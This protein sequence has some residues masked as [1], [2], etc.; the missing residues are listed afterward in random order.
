LEDSCQ[1]SGVGAIVTCQ[2]CEDLPARAETGG[3]GGGL[4]CATLRQDQ[5]E[6][7]QQADDRQHR[8]GGDGED[9][10]DLAALR[11]ARYKDFRVLRKAA[12][13]LVEFALAISVFMLLVF[14]T[15]DLAR[16]YLGYMVVTNA[17]REASR[18]AA[19]HAGDSACAANAQQA[20]LNLAVGID[21]AALT[22]T[23]ACGAPNAALTYISVSGIYR[24]HSVV[25]LVGAM[26]GDPIQIQV[27]TS[28]I[29]G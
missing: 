2:F 5:P 24:F 4:K 23:V 17:A 28:A 27:N 1:Y 9:H 14:G 18:Y 16:A 22:L 6:R 25:P 3:I 26:L 21:A 13:A 7:V 19:A 12:Q 20:G 10:H 15:F 11:L 29:A 8:R